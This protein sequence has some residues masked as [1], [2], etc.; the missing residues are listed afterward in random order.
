[1]PMLRRGNCG[2]HAVCETC[3]VSAQSIRCP[4]ASRLRFRRVFSNLGR[5]L[6]LADT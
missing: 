2:S 1:M 3:H 5:V 4:E 6:V